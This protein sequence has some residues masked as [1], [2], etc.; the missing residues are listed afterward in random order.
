MI[1]KPRRE[2]ETGLRARRFARRVSSACAHAGSIGFR[3]DRRVGK[4]Q[5]Y[6]L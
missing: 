1:P 3:I 5:C 2:F 6:D 4:R